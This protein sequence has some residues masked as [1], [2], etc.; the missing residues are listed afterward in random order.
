MWAYSTDLRQRVLADCDRGL[1]TREVAAKY[2]VSTLPDR[3]TPRNAARL[4]RLRE[5][6]E[7]IFKPLGELELR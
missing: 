1:A 2:S 5:Q 3:D 6:P 4:A 7:G